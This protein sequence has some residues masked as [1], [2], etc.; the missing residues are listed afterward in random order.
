MLIKQ[1]WGTYA[2]SGIRSFPTK[3][4]NTDT[5]LAREAVTCHHLSGNGPYGPTASVKASSSR[6]VTGHAAPR[7][8]IVRTAS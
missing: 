3:D 2:G 7:T 6:Y 8:G 1:N 4:A 5:N